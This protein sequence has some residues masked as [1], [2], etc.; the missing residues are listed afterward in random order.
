MTHLDAKLPP[1]RSLVA[2]EASARHANVTHAAKELGISREAVSRHIRTLEEF[3]GI[4]LFQRLHGAIALTP[5]GAAYHAIVR[6][7]LDGIANATDAVLD[8]GRPTGISVSTTVA[9]ASFWLTPRL[10]SF[11]EKYPNLEIHV[12]ISDAPGDLATEGTDVALRYGDGHWPGI[13]AVRLFGVNSFPVCSPEYLK[14]A[15]PIRGPQDLLRHTLVNLDGTVH[16]AEDWRW[17]LVGMGVEAPRSLR[18]LG[19]DNYANVIQATLAG[20]G[21]ALGFTGLATD[22]LASGRLVRPLEAELTKGLSVYLAT[23]RDRPPT[24]AARSFIYWIRAEAA[25][26]EG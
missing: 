15:G 8:L 6:E 13:T 26:T 24:P 5:A 12:K 18:L 10:A 22:L 16:M 4:K 2:F 19:F 11:R 7:S 20:Q 17:W 3:L 23:P 14:A 9:L 25:L 21:I 1:L